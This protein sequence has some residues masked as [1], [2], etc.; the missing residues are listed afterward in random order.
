MGYLLLLVLRD[1]ADNL[2]ADGSIISH[3]TSVGFNLA[4]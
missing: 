2:V 4:L 3:L 1:C